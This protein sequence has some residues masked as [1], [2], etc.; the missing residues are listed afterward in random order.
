MSV[1]KSSRSDALI[2]TQDKYEK[3]RSDR[4]RLP[5]TRLNYE[6]EDVWNEALELHGGTG[7]ETIMYALKL[8]IKEYYKPK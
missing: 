7:K 6:E 8:L 5:G 2:K 1:T 4:P 3:R